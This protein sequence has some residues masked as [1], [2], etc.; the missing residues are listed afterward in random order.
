M[1][2][3]EKYSSPPC[4]LTEFTWDCDCDLRKCDKCLHNYSCK[5]E[6]KMDFDWMPENPYDPK[7]NLDGY[8]GFNHGWIA[9]QKKLL[10]YQ[11]AK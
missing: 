5:V 4:D 6:K 3:T 2:T 11:L 8:Y 7:V 10:E 1:I 9:G